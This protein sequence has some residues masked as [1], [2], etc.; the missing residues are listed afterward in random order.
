MFDKKDLRI[1]NI[2]LDRY[3]YTHET[4]LS[5]IN[6]FGSFLQDL[7]LTNLQQ[8]DNL[9]IYKIEEYFKSRELTRNSGLGRQIIFIVQG[10]EKILFEEGIINEIKIDF[11]KNTR[12]KTIF[13]GSNILSVEIFQKA[14]LEFGKIQKKYLRD[15]EYSKEIERRNLIVTTIIYT[16][17]LQSS[18]ISG[19]R[20]ADI[21]KIDGKFYLKTK[22]DHESKFFYYEIIPYLYEEL[23]KYKKNLD[24]IGVFS[25]FLVCSLGRR[26][27]ANAL[28][29]KAINESVRSFFKVTK[30]N[31]TPI[32]VRNFSQFCLQS[33]IKIND[34]LYIGNQFI[35]YQCKSCNRESEL[36]IN[37]ICGECE[38]KSM[39]FSSKEINGYVYF[40]KTE[41][42]DY[43]K[44]GITKTDIQR[45]FSNIQSGNMFKLKLIGF[46]PSEN[47]RKLEKKIHSHFENKKMEGEWFNITS[48]NL[49]EVLEKL[50]L[51]EYLQTEWNH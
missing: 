41:D 39:N 24:I 13:R 48:N 45:R 42:Y 50:D 22:R 17:C 12:K 36:V 3:R 33:N 23:L 32:Q 51:S 5:Y 29:T 26:S 31:I 14:Y 21:K 8:I 47:P 6:S 35:R 11:Q 40:I 4:K 43:F 28:T 19:A 10:V 25:P 46:I 15:W 44:I 38:K 16:C 18:E 9:D 49:F 7:G 27:K 20:W 2:V 30:H 1:L 34:Y 37:N